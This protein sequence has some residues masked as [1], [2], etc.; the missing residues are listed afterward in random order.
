MKQTKVSVGPNPAFADNN[1]RN[2]GTV[3]QIYRKG[4][5]LPANEASR[6]SL[7]FLAPSSAEF[8]DPGLF[9]FIRLTTGILMTINS[10]EK[11]NSSEKQTSLGGILQNIGIQLFILNLLTEFYYSR[12]IEDIIIVKI[13]PGIIGNIIRQRVVST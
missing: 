2:I 4:N 5:R 11:L 9:A 13:F 7:T 8:Y 6:Y 3:E 10:N 1:L 12:I